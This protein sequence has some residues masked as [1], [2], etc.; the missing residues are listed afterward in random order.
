MPS[1]RLNPA[2]GRP[3]LVVIALA[4]LTLGGCAVPGFLTRA[5]AP[6]TP[7]PAAAP[8][9][10]AKSNYKIGP[11]YTIGGRVYRPA[12]D[13]GYVE[14]GTASWYGPKFHGKKTANGEI[15]DM[16]AVSAAHRTLPMPSL[17]RVTNLDNGRVLEARVNDR[18][19]FAKER[20]IDMSRAAARRLGFER[21]GTARV[22]VEILAEESRRMAAA[23]GEGAVSAAVDP[24]T[25]G[26]GYYVQT[27]AF[28][29]Y[30]NAVR[31]QAAL[32]ELGRFFIA[33]RT[34]KVNLYRVRIGPYADVAAADAMV[35][36]L[37]ANGRTGIYLAT[38]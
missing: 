30:R 28:A 32:A 7:P 36:R 34:A 26:D 20:I 10:G 25:A 13:Y 27:G 5:S 8:A 33:P 31:Q 21:Q 19:P 35:R 37:A 38:D 12:V 16:N 18:G 17:V 15:F 9:P 6:D 22:R 29:N 23:A 1:A 4:A 2:C 24:D 3:V 11:P 14:T